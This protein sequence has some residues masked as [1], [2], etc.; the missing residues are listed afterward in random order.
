M[1]KLRLSVQ[2]VPALDPVTHKEHTAYSVIL[3]DGDIVRCAP[4]WTL[5]D[6][7]ETF[8]EW[9]HVCRED[10]CLRRPFFPQKSNY[11]E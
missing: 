11:Y 5:R 1:E 10:V 9:F 2:T 3:R 8:C 4:G 7:I 6:A